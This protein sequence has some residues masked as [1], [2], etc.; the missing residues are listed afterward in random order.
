MTSSIN[1]RTKMVSTLHRDLIG[2]GLEDDDLAR[3][4]LPARPS[5]W[6][7]TGFLVPVQA[8]TEQRATAAVAEGALD[9]GEGADGLDDADE[10]DTPTAKPSFLPSSMGL[11][12][13]VPEAVR[14]V[15]VMACWGDYRA[16]YTET[17][18]DTPLLHDPPSEAADDE[19]TDTRQASPSSPR[20]ARR[21]VWHRTPRQETIDLVLPEGRAEQEV[22]DS[23]GLVLAVV[24][25]R[26]KLSPPEGRIAARSISLFVVNRREPRRGRRA[27]E[28]SVFQAALH[29]ES[30]PPFIARPDPRGYGSKD[31][32]ESLADLHYRDVAELAVGHNV[33]ADWTISEGICRQICT[34]W[35]PAGIIPRIVSAVPDDVRCTLD[36]DALGALRDF[37]AARLALDGLPNAYRDWIASQRPPCLG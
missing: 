1:I 26:V 10:P 30:D 6:Y 28:S 24:A 7:L 17:A 16:A 35:I 5:R 21:T 34:T 31:F 3:E 14:Q 23:R 13:L 25:R 12:F 9:S 33:S 32:D 27:D 37:A 36:M 11:S 15:R 29:V 18:E 20:P 19:A 22:P 2:P 8:P 4:V